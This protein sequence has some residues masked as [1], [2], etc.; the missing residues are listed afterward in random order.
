[1]D[2]DVVLVTIQYRLGPLGF[3]SLQ[4]DDIKVRLLSN[5]IYAMGHIKTKND[6]F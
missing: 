6:L 2:E 3:L 1:M 5:P 4:N